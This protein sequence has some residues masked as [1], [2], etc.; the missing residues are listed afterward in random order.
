MFVRKRGKDCFRIFVDIFAKIPIF[1]A[2]NYDNCQFLPCFAV[3]VLGE[4]GKGALPHQILY[5]DHNLLNSN[6]LKCAIGEFKLHKGNEY[7][8]SY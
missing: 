3:T 2:F 4:G 6:T 8:E 1:F 5:F 7:A